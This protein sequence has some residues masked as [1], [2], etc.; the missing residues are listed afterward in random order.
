MVVFSLFDPQ[1]SFQSSRLR[2]AQALCLVASGARVEVL[3]HGFGHS[4]SMTT[5][6]RT[7]RDIGT[8][9]VGPGMI[10]VSKG[11]VSR[12]S[13]NSDAPVKMIRLEDRAQTRAFKNPTQQRDTPLSL[14]CCL[15]PL[16][17]CQVSRL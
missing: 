14:D 12:V 6:A 11:P 1:L 3:L 8:S 13:C 5:L 15:F 2:C 9:R 10:K 4:P 17:P 7:N 16:E